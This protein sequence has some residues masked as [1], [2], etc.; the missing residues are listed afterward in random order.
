MR[1]LLIGGERAGKV[2]DIDYGITSV[3]FPVAYRIG[4]GAIRYEVR[5]LEDENGGAHLIAVNGDESPI[6]TLMKFYELHAK[7]ESQ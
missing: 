3:E 7:G 2:V 4:W 5:R 6:V 1:C